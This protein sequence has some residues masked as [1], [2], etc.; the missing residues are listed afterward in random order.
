KPEAFAAAYK[1]NENVNADLTYEGRFSLIDIGDG[2]GRQGISNTLWVDLSKLDT[3]AAIVMRGRVQNFEGDSYTKQYNAMSETGQF[4]LNEAYIQKINPASAIKF[5]LFHFE[6]LEPRFLDLRNFNYGFDPVNR[7]KDKKGQGNFSYARFFKGGDAEIFTDYQFDV[8][9]SNSMK[10]Y[11]GKYKQIR[12]FHAF[13]DSRNITI[14]DIEKSADDKIKLAFGARS[15]GFKY[16][17]PIDQMSIS[18]GFDLA[19]ILKGEAGLAAKKRE[20]AYSLEYLA[21]KTSNN[22]FLLA[23]NL[24]DTSASGILFPYQKSV[25]AHQLTM[26]FKNILNTGVTLRHYCALTPLFTKADGL[27]EDIAQ[28]QIVMAIFSSSYRGLEFETSFLKGYKNDNSNMLTER[29][30][31]R[32]LVRYPF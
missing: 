15:N 14:A 29:V 3:S 9:Y 18:A 26:K 32:T 12:L 6:P 16:L 21:N 19:K 28:M 10:I 8:D 7:P 22:Y 1:I 27:S 13:N 4:N 17:E 20:L 24:A 2:A 30:N 11:G 25:M 31:F 5:G 23:R